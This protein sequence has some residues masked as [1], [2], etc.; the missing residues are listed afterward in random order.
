M[1]TSCGKSTPEFIYV[2]ERN[3]LLPW[4][5]KQGKHEIQNYWTKK[6][7]TS[8]DGDPTN[9]TPLSGLAE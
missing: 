6:N 5:E 9:I 4:Y 2:G 3:I 8:I 1:Q 7:H